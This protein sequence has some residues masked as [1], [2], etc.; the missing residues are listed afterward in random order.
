MDTYTV[1][2]GDTLRKLA[3]QFG[4][5]VEEFASANSI[6]NPNL[7][8]VG[9]ELVIPGQ[10]AISTQGQASPITQSPNID[11]AF[12][13]ENVPT[14]PEKRDEIV[15]TSRLN[16]FGEIINPTAQDVDNFNA[17]YATH[18]PTNQ[19]ATQDPLVARQ[20]QLQEEIKAMEEAMARRTA[21]RTEELDVAGVFADM[22]ALNEKKAQLREAKSKKTSVPLEAEERLSG[23]GATIAEFEQA[24]YPELRKA[25]LAELKSSLKSQEL[26][27]RVN[28]KIAIIDQQLKG[29]NDQQD[30]VYKQKQQELEN[31]QKIYGD[32]MTEAQK[33]RA[34]EAKLVNDITMAQFKW[35]LDYK[36]DMLKKMAE[37]GVDTTGL[38]NAPLSTIQDRYAETSGGANII[39]ISDNDAKLQSIEKLLSPEMAKQLSLSVGVGRDEGLGKI[40]SFFTRAGQWTGGAFSSDFENLANNLASKEALDYFVNL[41]SRGA[42]FGALSNAELG[43]I[44]SASSLLATQQIKKTDE[45]GNAIGTGLFNAT[46]KHFKEALTTL[47]R[48]TMKDSLYQ[49]MG[50]SAYKQAGLVNEMDINA[51]KAIYD[52]WKQK[53]FSPEQP[54][55][56]NSIVTGTPI[57]SA[58]LPQRN[59]NPGNIKAGGLSDDLAVGTDSQG[60][61][62]FPTPEAG[63]EALIRDVQAKVSGNSKYLQANP[64]LAQLGSV[65]AEDPNWS[66]SVAKILG[67]TP[68]TKTQTI[69]IENLVLAI[70]RQ[71]GYFA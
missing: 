15:Q 38:V 34:E 51:V 14:V 44:T 13:P 28:T 68:E 62:I 35:E 47:Q 22:R 27:D 5:T 53:Q 64:T 7:I 21:V 41:K 19:T 26:T 63:F 29:I 46:E 58:N 56:L 24:T 66:N 4:K 60:H 59:N 30:F 20:T 39:K 40:S 9:Q 10:T 36:G 54:D 3:K 37:N 48:A 67:V 50:D 61:L 52:T 42:T 69:P 11:M 31:V 2:Q 17:K 33:A 8:K 32:I 65:Y 1:K 49:M 45:Q 18:A 55:Y 43:M 71:E 70:A 23:R 25:T 57:T 12:V 16:E 6:Q